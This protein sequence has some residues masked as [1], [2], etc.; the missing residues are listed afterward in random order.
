[1]HGTIP[2]SDQG[3]IFPAAEVRSETCEQ[4]ITA[5]LRS[6]SSLWFGELARKLWPSKTAAT[7]Q[8][9][10]G[11]KE[12]QCYSWASGSAEPF[13][14]VLVALLRSDDGERVLDRVLSGCGAAWNRRRIA[15]RR[16][17]AILRNAFAEFQLEL[18]FDPSVE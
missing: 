18:K 3:A 10:T 9:L 8:F 17:A 14:S 15:D 1:M 4:T 5:E 13:A 6:D 2:A 11:R 16:D 12:R 7:L